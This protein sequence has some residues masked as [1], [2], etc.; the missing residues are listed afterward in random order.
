MLL[1]EGEMRVVNDEIA[2]LEAQRRILAKSIKH[3]QSTMNKLYDDPDFREK[4][5]KTKNELIKAKETCGEME[6]YKKKISTEQAKVIKTMSSLT[7]TTRRLVE[8]KICIENGVQLS[9]VTE[10][11]EE[12]D[13]ELSML[14]S[15]KKMAADIHKKKQNKIKVS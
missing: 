8:K 11:N 2:E 13:H 9:K 6:E 10:D 7:A 4:M 5:V 15:R 3:Q 14:Q 12:L 1:D